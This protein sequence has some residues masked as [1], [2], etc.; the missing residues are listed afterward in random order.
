[1]RWEPHS[2]SVDTGRP[3]E[4]RGAR[5]RSKQPPVRRRELSQAGSGPVG[6]FQLGN[7]LRGCIKP[8]GNKQDTLPRIPVLQCSSITLNIFTLNC[9]S[10]EPGHKI[11]L[12]F[13]RQILRL[14]KHS[15]LGCLVDRTGPGRRL[16]HR[17]GLP[18]ASEPPP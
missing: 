12:A 10:Y 11:Q 16:P 8:Q 15:L 4:C 7:A 13:K 17:S 2:P 5:H 18:S 1:M 14:Q 9:N 6:P 3:G